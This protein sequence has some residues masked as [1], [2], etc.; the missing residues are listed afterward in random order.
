MLHPLPRE[1]GM[2]KHYLNCIAY[3]LDIAFRAL[4]YS[5]CK[6]TPFALIIGQIIFAL[7]ADTIEFG[8]IPSPETKFENIN[9]LLTK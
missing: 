3:R 2:E 9:L 7:I 1:T 5:Q 8:S 6:R 4:H